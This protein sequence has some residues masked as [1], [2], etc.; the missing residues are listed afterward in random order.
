ME[1]M[2]QEK[3]NL[4]VNTL[5]VKATPTDRIEMTIYGS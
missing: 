2:D 4:Q 3:L 5:R 1:A